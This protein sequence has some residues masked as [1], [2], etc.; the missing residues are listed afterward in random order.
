MDNNL[1][2]IIKE[3]LTLI[4]EVE[5]QRRQEL[6]EL[7]ITKNNILSDSV[8]FDLV[9]NQKIINNYQYDALQ[10]L[11][12]K[13][14]E[15]QEENNHIYNMEIIQ[16]IFELIITNTYIETINIEILTLI[17]EIY[18]LEKEQNYIPINKLKLLLSKIGFFIKFNSIK[19]LYIKLIKESKANT[20]LFKKNH[21]KILEKMKGEENGKNKN[22]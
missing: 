15:E 11:N 19:E 9:E 2:Y 12:K 16:D 17:S 5:E 22:F 18:D 14:N 3:I 13:T 4:N 8:L 20:N 1:E 6:I 21:D 7:I 10:M